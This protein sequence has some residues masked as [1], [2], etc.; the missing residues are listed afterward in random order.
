MKQS[1][2]SEVS[3]RSVCL[4]VP[5]SFMEEKETFPCSEDPGRGLFRVWW[6]LSSPTNPVS[7]RSFSV[8]SVYEYLQISKV[9]SIIQYFWPGCCIHACVLHVRPFPVNFSYSCQKYKTLFPWS[10]PGGTIVPRI[11]CIASLSTVCMHCPWFKLGPLGGKPL[12]WLWNRLSD[13]GRSR[14]RPSDFRVTR[15]PR[16]SIVNSESSV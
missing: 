9:A 13:C 10:Y 16:P 7:L 8:W 2:P 6:I 5:G 4:E 1:Y 11:D 3:I 14:K 12:R 15:T